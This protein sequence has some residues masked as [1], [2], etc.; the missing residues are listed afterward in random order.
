MSEIEKL[1][2]DMET[3]INELQTNNERY[4]QALRDIAQKAR[5]Y[6]E[7]VCG[8]TNSEKRCDCKYIGSPNSGSEATGC[9]EFREI[10][11]DAEIALERDE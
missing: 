6:R 7:L 5:E 4:K 10:C 3:K 9:C 2:R 11:T 1:M 8:Y